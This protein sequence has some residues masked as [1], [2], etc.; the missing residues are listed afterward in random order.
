[1][2]IRDELRKSVSAV[3]GTARASAE[4]AVRSVNEWAAQREANRRIAAFDDKINKAAEGAAQQGNNGLHTLRQGDDGGPARDP[5]SLHFDPFDIVAA[6]G[7]RE[8]PTAL[9]Y[10]AMEMVGK[11]TPVIA[12]VIRARVSQVSMFCEVPE[13]RHSPG[14]K[15]RLRDWKNNTMSKAAEQEADRIE[16]FLLYTG[17]YDPERPW[18]AVSLREFAAMA[19]NDTLTYDQLNFEVV[20][21]NKGDPAYFTIVDPTTI[22]LLDPGF[23]NPG[24][25]FAV[26]VINGL[27]HADFTRDELAFCVRNP[28]SGIRSYGYGQSEIETLVKEITGFLWAMHY[29]RAFFTNGSATKGILNFKGTIPDRHLQS[30]RRQWYAMVTGVTNAWRTPITN[31]EELQWINMQMSNRDMEYSA[32]MDFLIKIVCARYQ[33]APEEVNFQYGNSGQ[34]QAMGT[35]P[36]EE[37]VKASKDLGLRPLVRWFFVQ[38]NQHVVQRLNPDFEV[39]PCGMREKG[40]EAETDLLKNQT[41]VYLTVDEAREIAEYP[42]LGPEKGGDAILNQIWLS[43]T[44]GKQAQEQQQQQ[45][46]AGQPQPGEEGGPGGPPAP[47]EHEDAPGQQDDDAISSENDMDFG[48]HDD[49]NDAGSFDVRDS[50]TIKSDRE[51]DA[52]RTVRYVVNLD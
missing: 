11:G 24:D 45:T 30:F 46:Q 52:L 21:T 20:P 18:D 40:V 17:H 8:R 23:R 50:D 28:R 51:A 5:K 49:L 10:Q 36:V 35:A 42:P 25:P 34:S 32:W 43:W 15:V 44:Q 9:T 1:M 2:G 13:D 38:L 39:V 48:V 47:P 6:M 14:F 19:I 29:N 12:D 31:A 3:T 22:R 16:Q 4:D 26:Q 37:K 41:S 27:V 7:F 33:I